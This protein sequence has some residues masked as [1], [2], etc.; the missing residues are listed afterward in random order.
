MALSISYALLKY[1]IFNPIAKRMVGTKSPDAIQKF[2]TAE[3]KFTSYVFLSAFGIFTIYNE[4]WCV[5]PYNFLVDWRNHEFTDALRNYYALGTSYYLFVTLLMFYEPR[6]KDRVQ[7][8]VH[9]AVTVLLL[10][11]SYASGYFRIGAAV[12]LLHDLS[13]PFMEL[14]KLF[15]YCQNEMV[16]YTIRN[17]KGANGLY[18]SKY[19]FGLECIGFLMILQV[20][21]I[22]WTGLILKIAV[23]AII[24]NKVED[25]REKNE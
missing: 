10:T 20:L 3:W 17:Q 5:Y 22:F 9:H 11:F 14:A 18:L 2:V 7:M 25:I 13:D 6:M 19:P 8:F 4:G 21:H 16:R 1:F 23:N 12:M 15:N 24:G